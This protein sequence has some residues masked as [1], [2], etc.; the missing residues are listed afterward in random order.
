MSEQAVIICEQ[1][2]KTYEEGGTPLAVLQGINLSVSSGERI[3]IVGSSG[4]GKSTL[5]NIIGGLD[6]PTSG[7]VSVM[8][9]P[10]MDLNENQCARLRNE[11]LGFV[12]QFH[13]LLGEFSALENVAMP[14]LLRPDVS[15]D[16][17][18]RRSRELLCR[19][20]L[21]KRLQHKPAQLSGGERQRV[22]IARALV[23][24]PRTVLMDEPTGNLDRHTADDVQAL[25]LELNEQLGTAF[26]VVT[27]DQMLASRMDR[28]LHLDEGVL[29]V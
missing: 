9:T 20:G 8:G 2:S 27:H 19:V 11:S 12:Y 17:I 28:V 1:V 24:H 7:M 21:E 3:A 26:V 14:L 29:Q 16:E 25:M 6:R 5:L 18:E 22:A 4:S 15:R 10:L 13:H 23:T